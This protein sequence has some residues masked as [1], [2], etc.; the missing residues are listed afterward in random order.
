V[1]LRST[2]AREVESGWKPLGRDSSYY[3]YELFNPFVVEKDLVLQ[4][5]QVLLWVC[6]MERVNVRMLNTGTYPVL[7][8]PG[9][10]P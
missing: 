2:I 9:V 5:M 8:L 1:R 6:L 3:L 10:N 4:A 7:S